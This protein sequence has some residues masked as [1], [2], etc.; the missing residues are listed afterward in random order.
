MANMN[1]SSICSAGMT[2]PGKAGERGKGVGGGGVGISVSG[3]LRR[4]PNHFAISMA[5]A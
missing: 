4:P 5:L 2:R 3:L 1:S